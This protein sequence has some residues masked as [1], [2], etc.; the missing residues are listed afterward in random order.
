MISRRGVLTPQAAREFRFSDV[1]PDDAQ[2]EARANSF[3]VPRAERTA[4]A[5]RDYVSWHEEY[6]QPG[7]ALHLRLLVVRELVATALD[8]LPA[9]P[10]RAI[11]LCAGQGIDLLPVAHR[12]RRGVDLTGRLI[13][14][15]PG[16]VAIARKNIERFRLKGLEA[17]E[18]DAGWSDVYAGAAPADLVLVCGVFGNI[19]DEDVERT[20]RLL[21]SLCAQGAWVI[22]TR[23]PRDDGIIFRI[24]DWFLE[25]GFESQAL[26]VP[27]VKMFGV[28][29]VLLTGNPTPFRSGERL[30]ENLR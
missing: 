15:D 29:A 6:A 4:M 2:T 7:S 8:Q 21:P 5:R 16:N 26:V 13:E 30:F 25:A 11:S 22:W 17:V 10:I 28:G 23:Y 14:L 9:G 1:G 27:E 24:Q 18:G 19:R 12:H 3:R 20:V